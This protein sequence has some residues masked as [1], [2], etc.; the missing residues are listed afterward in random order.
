MPS[1]HLKAFEFHLGPFFSRMTKIFMQKHHHGCV[2]L[3]KV[4]LTV[5]VSNLNHVDLKTNFL[6]F[7]SALNFLR[8]QW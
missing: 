5:I 4:I 2:S 8:F 6:K 7:I 1:S 3:L